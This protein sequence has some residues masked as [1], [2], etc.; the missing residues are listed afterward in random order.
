M[1][2]RAHWLAGPHQL[3]RVDRHD[4]R[5]LRGR[6]EIRKW[7]HL[8]KTNGSRSFAKKGK[9]ERGSTYRVM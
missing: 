7:R 9:R 3:N 6:W 1:G 2:S 8:L 4:W 5:G